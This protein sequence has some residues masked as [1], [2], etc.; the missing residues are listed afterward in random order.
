MSKYCEL[1]FYVDIN[2]SNKSF[3]ILLINIHSTVKQV[4]WTMQYWMIA[5]QKIKKRLHSFP[6]DQLNKSHGGHAGSR[7]KSLIKVIL[8]RNTNMAAVTSCANALLFLC[9]QVCINMVKTESIGCGHVSISGHDYVYN[10]LTC[11]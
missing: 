8:N 11:V 2:N 5:V 6:R 9:A 1:G 10:S 4:D 3:E 7:Q